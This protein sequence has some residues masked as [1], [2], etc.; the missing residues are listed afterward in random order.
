MYSNINNG[1]IHVNATLYPVTV[2]H[3]I[4]AYKKVTK[5]MRKLKLRES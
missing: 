4:V 1:F 3:K 5:Y 2:M